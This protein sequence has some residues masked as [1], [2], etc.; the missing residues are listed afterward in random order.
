MQLEIHIRNRRPYV[1]TILNE[2]LARLRSYSVQ[3]QLHT[4][5][6]QVVLAQGFTKQDW[7]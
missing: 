5:R 3:L 7:K 1:E 4:L 2:R 6:V